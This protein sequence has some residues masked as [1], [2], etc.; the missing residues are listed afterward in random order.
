MGPPAGAGEGAPGALTLVLPDVDIWLRAFSRHQ[1]DPL[2]VHAF[3]RAVGERRVVLVGAVQQ[4]VLARLR[5]EGAAARMAALLAAF[6][7]L[8]AVGADHRRAAELMRRGGPGGA[9]GAGAAL[10]WA[11]AERVRG[12]VWSREARWVAWGRAGCP[13]SLADGRAAD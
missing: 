4:Q 9:P 5:D 3:G 11:Q 1:P 2:V 13:V 10:L 7:L 6:P 12:V 8:R